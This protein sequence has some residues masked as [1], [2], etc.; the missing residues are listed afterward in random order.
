MNYYE[1]LGVS[2]NAT[3]NEIKKRY[4]Q[5]AI[6]YHPDKNP[7]SSDKFKKVNE[8]Y[9]TLSDPYKRGKYDCML[10]RGQHSQINDM[11]GMNFASAMRSFNDLFRNDPFFNGSWNFSKRP[12]MDMMGMNFSGMQGMEGI[13]GVPGMDFG[14]MFD[15]SNLPSDSNSFQKSYSSST[16]QTRG[17]DGKLRSKSRVSVNNN[18][19]KDSFYQEYYIGADGKKHIVKQSG[20]KN[21]TTNRSERHPRIGYHSHSPRKKVYRLKQG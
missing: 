1:I 6:K 10:E 4:K 11:F 15:M 20:N 17:R 13:Q 18:G 2:K 16:I 12:D 8:A 19:K 7:H 5:L 3:Y 21:L 14:N 9:K